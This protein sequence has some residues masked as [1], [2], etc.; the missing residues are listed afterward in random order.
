MA[1]KARTRD[2]NAYEANLLDPINLRLLE[3]LTA[4]G[5]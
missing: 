1:R 4:D 5:R 3:E 2:A